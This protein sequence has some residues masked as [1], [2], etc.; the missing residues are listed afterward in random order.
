[1]VVSFIGRLV[2]EK[3][4]LDLLEA[5]NQIEQ[6]NLK[7][8]VIGGTSSSERDQQLSTRLE[9]YRNNSNITFT[10]F[11][12][13][14]PELLAFSD[15]YCLPSYREGMPR[16]IIE[17]MS[18]E[19]A[20]IATNIRGSRE[21]VDHGENGYLVNLKSP[22]EIASSISS[23]V[24]NNEALKSFRNKARNKALNLYNEKIVVKKQMNI[25]ESIELKKAHSE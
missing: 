3:G 22:D 6:D 9:K 11:R 23:L 15:I 25:F 20:I 21:E 2:K 4:I 13:D 7:L 14:I 1:M 8:L 12:S 10:G 18:M 16:S 5:F 19:C 17:A 24:S